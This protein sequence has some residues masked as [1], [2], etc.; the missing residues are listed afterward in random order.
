MPIAS[1]A[2]FDAVAAGHVFD[3]FDRVDFGGVDAVG[4]AELLGEIKLVVEDVDGD[5]AAGAGDAGALDD[6][7]A[8]AA[9]A[10]HGRRFAP[11]GTL[12]V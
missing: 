12:A 8:D 2:I 6:V 3:R 9:A 4:G 10:D 1:K 7:E 5:D 11:P